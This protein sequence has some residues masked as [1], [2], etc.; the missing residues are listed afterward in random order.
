[1]TSRLFNQYLSENY[2]F[3][4]DNKPSELIKNI[5]S[6]DIVRSVISITLSGFRE[7]LIVLGLIVLIGYTNYKIALVLII[8]GIIFIIF[9]KL[10]ISKILKS[11]GKKSYI[12]QENFL[13]FFLPQEFFLKMMINIY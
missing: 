5:E 11:Y 9:H 8:L 12:F 13:L 2:L 7:I 4:I 6:V 1:M 3:F 10:K